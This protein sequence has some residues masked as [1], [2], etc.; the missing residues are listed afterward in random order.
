MV[1]IR[2]NLVCVFSAVKKLAGFHENDR[3]RDTDF[4]T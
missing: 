4:F 1:L 2:N 3:I